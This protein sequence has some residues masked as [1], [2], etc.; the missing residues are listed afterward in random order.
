MARVVLA[1]FRQQAANLTLPYACTSPPPPPLQLRSECEMNVTFYGACRAAAE[2]V[3][4]YAI[5]M[6][7]D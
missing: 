1:P 5:C 7:N 3:S 4:V 6:P 2:Q